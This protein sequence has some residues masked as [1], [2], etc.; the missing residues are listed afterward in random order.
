MVRPYRQLAVAGGTGRCRTFRGGP[1]P[2]RLDLRHRRKTSCLSPVSKLLRLVEDELR[3]R[4]RGISNQG[5]SFSSFN[6]K[7]KQ[8][9]RILLNGTTRYSL[10]MSMDDSFG[11]AT[12]RFYGVPGSSVVFG[13]SSNAW[14]SFVFDENTKAPALELHDMSLIDTLSE[15]RRYSYGDF[16]DALWERVCDAIESSDS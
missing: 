11:Q 6:S 2:R 15:K 1:N 9:V 14:G 10:D 8:C 12:V 5:I 16:I 7:G 4:C 3:T 13:D